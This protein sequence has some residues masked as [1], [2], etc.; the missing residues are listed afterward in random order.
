MAS[1]AK[2]APGKLLDNRFEIVAEIGRGGM[3][4]VFK[5]L[6]RTSGEL[7][8]LKIPL[9]QYASGM[10]SWSMFQREA[11]I[12][13]SLSHPNILRYLDAPESRRSSYIVSEYV[14]G[15]VLA[16]R[17]GR[18]RRLPEGEAVHILRELCG[19][20]AYLHAQGFVHYDLKPN[21]VLERADGS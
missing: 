7:V 20:V 21:N 6:D 18:G 17:V 11:E 2:A 1:P 4:T 13:R 12:G 16:A 8:A 19:A 5:A 3:A 15:P 14:A 9:P 10:G